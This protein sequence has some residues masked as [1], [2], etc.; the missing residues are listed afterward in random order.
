MA[1]N[2]RA[3]NR[4]VVSV[5]FDVE[6]LEKINAACEKLGIDRTKF[7]SEAVQEKLKQDRD[8]NP[9]PNN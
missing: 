6:L 4:K 9:S 1:P 7:V 2:Q 8:K 5:T 3:D